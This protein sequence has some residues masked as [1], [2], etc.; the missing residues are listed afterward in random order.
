MTVHGAENRGIPGWTAE[1]HDLD[2]EYD[3][4][5]QRKDDADEQEAASTNRRTSVVGGVG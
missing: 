2:A 4:R 5:E 3:E 1:S